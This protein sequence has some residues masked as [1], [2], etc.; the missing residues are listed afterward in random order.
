MESLMAAVAEDGDVRWGFAADGVV[1]AMVNL[2]VVA[3]VAQ[4]ASVLGVV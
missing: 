4:L 1:R 2:E 3:A